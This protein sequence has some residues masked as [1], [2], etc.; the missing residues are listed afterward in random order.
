VLSLYLSRTYVELQRSLSGERGQF[1]LVNVFVNLAFLL[2]SYFFMRILDYRELGTVAL[3][4]AI[5]LLV[6]ALQLGILNGGYRMLC[7]EAGEGARRIND[8]TWS[9]VAVIALLCL[10][11]T[12]LLLRLT[13][14]GGYSQVAY[15]GVLAGLGTLLKTWITNVLVARSALRQLNLVN[16]LSSALSLLVL[17]AASWNP[18]LICMLSLLLQPLLFVIA[19]IVQDR[20]L[21]PRTFSLRRDLLHSALASGF[22][23][24]LTSVFQLANGQMERW[25]IVSYDGT[26]TLGHYYLALLF[27]NLYALIPTSLDAIY[28]PLL[29]RAYFDGDHARVR[30]IMGRFVGVTIAYTIGA[31]LLTLAL[32]S[33]VIAAVLPRY[34][35]DLKY[36]YLLLPGLMLFG[37]TAPL[38]IVFNVVIQ[39]RFY[40][41][42]YGL[43]SV[44][45]ALLLATIALVSHSAD[46]TLV[47]L[48][49]TAVYI[50]MAV[51][52][53]IGYRLISRVYPQFR[54]Q[55][56]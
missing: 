30:H 34:L 15:L 35:V 38:A 42:G 43:G 23:V 18:L 47:S 14:N 48:A 22:V 12:A 39:Y 54:L 40:F 7:A 10:A 5:V 20:S 6:G 53:A 8:F 26:G 11:A 36:V 3:L 9:F 2:R 4:Q 49:K 27:V 31:A 56:A 21:V 33:P 24:F 51:V 13:A 52:I 46:L 55:R 28:L 16:V 45:T 17:L 44:L 19:A 50:F 37:L 29:V 32:A 1:V 25:F 41:I